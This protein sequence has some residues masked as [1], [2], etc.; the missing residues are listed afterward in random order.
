MSAEQITE[1]ARRSINI[2]FISNPKGTSIGVLAGVVCDGV[3]GLFAPA[4]KAIELINIAAIKAWHLIG[5]GVITA[6]LPS[7]LRRSE[8]EPSI[9]KAIDFIEEQKKKGNINEWQARQMYAN[10]HSKVLD[11][12]V[13]DN[14]SKDTSRK[15][16][17]LASQPRVGD[18]ESNN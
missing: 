2:L 16:N 17:D 12:I 11:N 14:N 13:L 10:L 15:I 7:Y 4:L 1:L 9:V 6:N 8:I 3:L 18:E 5:L